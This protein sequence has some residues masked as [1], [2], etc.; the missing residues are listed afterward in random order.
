MIEASYRRVELLDSVESYREQI[1]ARWTRI[2]GFMLVTLG[3]S[4]GA[5]IVIRF[6]APSALLYSPLV[7][8]A[9]LF[10]MAVPVIVW[11]NPRAGLY[12]LTLFA[13]L[14][15]QSPERRHRDPLEWLPFYWSGSVI[16]ENYMGNPKA[17]DFINFNYAELVMIM[18]AL[19]WLTR[20]IT[21]RELKFY[22]GAFFPWL[23]LFAVW[24]CWGMFR[25][26]TTGG[27]LVV[28]L[29]EMRAQAYFF[30]AYLLATHLVTERG[31]AITLLWI[32]LVGIS[33]KSF[34]GT[35]NWIKDPNV[36]PDQG[37]LS[38]ED[39]LLM[40]LIFLGALVFWLA[41][42]E[43]QLKWAFLLMIPT[44]LISSLANGRRAGIASFIVAFPAVVMLSAVLLKERRKALIRFS[45]AFGIL[46]AIYLPIAWN[47]Q[48]AW[49]LPARAIR[50]RT[51]PDARDAASDAYRY[52]ENANLKLTRD[53]S[54]WLGYGYGK[55]YIV[56][57]TQ[58]GRVDPFANVLPHNGIY[59]VWMRLGHP[60]FLLFWMC[61]ANVLIQGPMLMKR[62]QDP[63]LQ[64][65]GI[66]SI[67]ALLML[68][69]YGEYDLSFANYRPMWL[70]GTLLGVLAALPRID[71]SQEAAKQIGDS[72]GDSPP[73][74]E[75]PDASDDIP[76]PQRRLPW[77]R[78]IPGWNPGADW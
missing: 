50:S 24:V 60:G 22:P 14:C 16:S 76:L 47:G 2:W 65:I 70:T 66:L 63:R 52:A 53:T 21:L 75:P 32:M 64:A 12:L 27:S 15:V 56:A 5:I 17:L 41:R 77:Q 48:G 29:W 49:A 19:F 37:V 10:V 73:P 20:Q 34:V 51:S 4:M 58:W 30:I 46:T 35:A 38:H 62:V 18:T 61:V 54:P 69:I 25:G 23:A 6:L 42:Q 74:P 44:A 3:A 36:T 40:N 26:L 9:V 1:R 78:Q 45:V 59:W 43:P 28:A 67:A 57:H 7:A 68:I 8:L 72:T 11:N 13:C 39:S 71:A 31:H 33:M 55:P